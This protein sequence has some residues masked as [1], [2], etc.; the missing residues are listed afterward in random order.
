M[1]KVKPKTAVAYEKAVQQFEMWCSKTR[2][3]RRSHKQVDEAF[4]LYLN[5]LCKEGRPVNDGSYAVYGWILL[6]SNE[7]LDR[8]SQL[9]FAK[10]CLKGWN[11]RYPTKARCGVD[12]KIWDAI[13]WECC[14]M[15]HYLS[16]A[17]ILVQGDS[18][19]R[20]SEVFEITQRHII[21]PLASRGRGIWGVIVGLDEDG[22]PT[23]TGDFDD[24]VLFNTVSRSDVN[25]II[26]GLYHSAS[27]PTDCLFSPLS[28]GQ[29]TQHI[30]EAARRLK[31]SHLHLTP[32]V[33][34]HSG[35][36]HDAY[37]ELR[38]LKQIQVRGRWKAAES[39]RRYRKPGRMLLSHK[40]VPRA[41]W[42]KAVKARQLV[43]RDV[44][45]FLKERKS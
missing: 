19:L 34:R 2:V 11:S 13:A 7:H 27:D 16:A 40:E 31:L 6:R 23:K 5:H 17:A 3:P 29:Y 38:D 32:H 14:E 36:S 43:I 41:T 4:C 37:Y 45:K 20:P 44:T 15:G 10:Q 26:S 39:V 18:Y 30:H 24:C 25:L 33:I 35:P 8:K 9:P 1:G 28:H 42:Q 21:P 22:K 12:L